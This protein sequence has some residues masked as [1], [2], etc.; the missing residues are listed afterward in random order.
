MKMGAGGT[1]L[2]ELEEWMRQGGTEGTPNTFALFPQ[3]VQLSSYPSC[4][5]FSIGYS[6]THT[7]QLQ[8]KWELRPLLD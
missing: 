4:P 1:Q 7:G 8:L 5:D 3:F 6:H 2:Q